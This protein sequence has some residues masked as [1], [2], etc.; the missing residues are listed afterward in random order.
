MAVPDWVCYGPVKKAKLCSLGPLPGY[1]ELRLQIRHLPNIW[2]YIRFSRYT[3]RNY[4]RYTF[5]SLLGEL[6]IFLFC[7]IFQPTL[8]NKASYSPTKTALVQS[9]NQGKNIG[10][11]ADNYQ[12]VLQRKSIHVL[13]KGKKKMH[14]HWLPECN[15]SFCNTKVIDKLLP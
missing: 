4:P 5:L 15:I 12:H 3:Y 7:S 10:F 9:N 1:L 2:S 6:L 8:L 14:T 13:E 11:G